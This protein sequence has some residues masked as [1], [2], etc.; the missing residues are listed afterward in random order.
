MAEVPGAEAG[1][2]GGLVALLTQHGGA[3]EADL[4]RFYKIRLS[5]LTSGRLTWRRLRVLLEH[6][7]RG[8]A[9]ARVQHG[10]D[11]EWGLSEHLMA[12]AVD[13]LHAGN[14]QRSGGK[15]RQPKPLPRPG[16]RQGRPLTGDQPTTGRP[17]VDPEKARAYLD[18][19]KPKGA[20]SGD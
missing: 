17:S 15:G 19:F 5:H 9:L 3:I 7:P 13:A 2:I 18:Q 16:V 11:A 1:G 14:W 20:G 12:G 10:A 8:S 6:L 4:Q